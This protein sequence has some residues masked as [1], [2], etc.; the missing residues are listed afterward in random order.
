MVHLYDIYLYMLPIF[1][2]LS[3]ESIDKV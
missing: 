1:S 3:V 2:L